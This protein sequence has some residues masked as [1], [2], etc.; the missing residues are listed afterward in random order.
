MGVMIVTQII[1][2][3]VTLLLDS[4][5][6]IIFG[7]FGGCKK[8]IGSVLLFLKPISQMGKWRLSQICWFVPREEVGSGGLMT[9]WRKV[10]GIRGSQ[11]RQEF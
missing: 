1:T 9:D 6:G 2:V 4:V 8:L 5:K 3:I 11:S 10:C 7:L